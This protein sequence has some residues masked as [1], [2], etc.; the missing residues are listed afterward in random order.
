MTLHQLHMTYTYDDGMYTISMH[1]PEKDVEDIKDISV[2]DGIGGEDK[3]FAETLCDLADVVQE[4]EKRN[5]E[6]EGGDEQTDQI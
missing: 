3:S 4:I 5:D 1:I 2:V 6:K